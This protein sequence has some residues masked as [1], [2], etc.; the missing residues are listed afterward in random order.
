MSYGG[1]ATT[2]TGVHAEEHAI[3]HT[4]PD[5]RL[6]PNED[7]TLMVF[8]SVKIIPLSEQ[9]YLDGASRIN[10]RKV[11]TV[12]YNV[13]VWFTGYVDQGSESAVITSYNQANPPLGSSSQSSANN[14]YRRN[15]STYNGS[16]Y[17]T[18]G[19]ASNISGYPATSNDPTSSDYSNTA[20]RS[21]YSGGAYSSTSS[22]S[23][24]Y[25]VYNNLRTNPP[26]QYATTQHSGFQYTAPGHSQPQY[27]PPRYPTSQYPSTITNNGQN[28]GSYNA[29]HTYG[30]GSGRS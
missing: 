18:Q 20:S 21:S 8:P 5:A 27:A 17:F 11:Y 2:K 6:I 13:K 25:G 24:T 22:N 10:Y 1:R 23:S 28:Y 4:T 16:S 15:A 7:G 3:I 19:I 9:H 26:G 30:S 12:E 29:D 14:P